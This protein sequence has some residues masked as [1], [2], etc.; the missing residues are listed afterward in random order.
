MGRRDRR[1]VGDSRP[2]PARRCRKRR[3]PITETLYRPWKLLELAF[4]RPSSRPVVSPQCVTK[5]FCSSRFEATPVH[6]VTS[7]ISS[8][9]RTNQQDVD[10]LRLFVALRLSIHLCMVGEG[11]ITNPLLRISRPKNQ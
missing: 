8:G 6:G 4:A 10:W 1:P 7:R 11:G 5:T 2:E 9:R 3:G